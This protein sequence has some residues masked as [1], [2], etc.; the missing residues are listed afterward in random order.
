M[1]FEIDAS[2]KVR[3]S[4]RDKRV[5]PFMPAAAK[6][7]PIMVI[8]GQP[9]QSLKSSGRL[10]VKHNSNSTFPPQIFSKFLLCF[11]VTLKNYQDPDDK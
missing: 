8:T 10:N 3:H 1:L 7:E 4:F 2:Q 9:K 5:N 6:L 11:K